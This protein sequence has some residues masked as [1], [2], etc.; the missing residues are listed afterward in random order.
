M[1]AEQGQRCS[2]GMA[3]LLGVPLA[4]L[5]LG[6]CAEQKTVVIIN[7]SPGPGPTHAPG[8]IQ[9]P[10]KLSVPAS[11]PPRPPHEAAPLV[12]PPTPPGPTPEPIQPQPPLLVVPQTVQQEAQ[13][14]V[15]ACEA[16]ILNTER[17]L[18]L[19]DQ[20]RLNG[21]QQDLFLTIQSFLA[22]AKLALSH[23]DLLRANTLA[24]K[25]QTLADELTQSGP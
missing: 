2:L 10:A 15:E 25:A 3:L 4:A 22:K 17:S 19:L 1:R 16:R 7:P 24:D 12:P 18:L 20:T 14:G 6:G 5:L 9:A 23:K 13:R 11:I 21:A 8:S